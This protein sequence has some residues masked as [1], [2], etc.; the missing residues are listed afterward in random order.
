MLFEAVYTVKSDGMGIGLS[1]C[2]SFVERFRGCLWAMQNDGPEAAFS[3]SIPCFLNYLEDASP[4]KQKIRP[5]AR[6]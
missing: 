1:V 5:W 4:S 2:R 3:F 6:G